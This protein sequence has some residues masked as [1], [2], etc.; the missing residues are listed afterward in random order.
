VI[1]EGLR[2]AAPGVETSLFGLSRHLMD[3]S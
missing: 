2:V 1:R 3:L